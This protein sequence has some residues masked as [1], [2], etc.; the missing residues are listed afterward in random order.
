MVNEATAYGLPVITTN[1]IAE[2]EMVH[3][4]ESGFIVP[5]NDL[6][7]LILTLEIVLMTE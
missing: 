7:T 4:N 2:L 1:C 3:N 6:E 5:C